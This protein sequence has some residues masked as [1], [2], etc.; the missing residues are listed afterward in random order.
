M[1]T[2]NSG[3]EFTGVRIGRVTQRLITK[4]MFHP[5]TSLTGDTL[6]LDLY[7]TLYCYVTA[8]SVG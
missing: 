1:L 7:V 3:G 5:K 8:H 4:M 6:T 2:V